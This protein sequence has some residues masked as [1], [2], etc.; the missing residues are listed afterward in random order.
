MERSRIDRAMINKLENGKI[1]NPTY[2]TLKA[3]ANALG[4]RLLWTVQPLKD[5]PGANS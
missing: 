3:Y 1:P 5:D 4:L 2:T